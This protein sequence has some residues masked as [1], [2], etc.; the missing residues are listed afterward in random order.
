MSTAIAESKS[1]SLKTRLTPEQ[2]AWLKTLGTLVGSSEEEERDNDAGV[3]RPAGG[4]RGAAGTEKPLAGDRLDTVQAFAPGDIIPG[5]KDL[6]G[7]LSATCNITNNTDQTLQLDA[8]FL[9]GQPTSGEFKS[10][11]PIQIPPKQPAEFVCV[12]K[13]I[14]LLGISTAG[15]EGRVRYF[16]GDP[17]TTW[18]IHFDNPRVN[19]PFGD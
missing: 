11:P 5:I 19:D 16:V 18:T 7:T 12:S 6:L 13:K 10:P 14:P 8:A 3:A 15:A 1:A 9:K 2:R 4:R 17:K